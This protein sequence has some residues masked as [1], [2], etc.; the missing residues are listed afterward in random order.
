MEA[1]GFYMVQECEICGISLNTDN[2][3]FPSFN[4]G[5]LI[6]FK[7]KMI[8]KKRLKEQGAVERAGIR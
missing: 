8:E 1:W 5:R 7:C 6:C 4:K 3:H 2:I